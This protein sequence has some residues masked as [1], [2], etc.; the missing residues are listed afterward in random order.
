[1]NSQ[2]LVVSA[3]PVGIF[4]GLLLLRKGILVRLSDKTDGPPF[5]SDAG[6]RH[7]DPLFAQPLAG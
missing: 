2:T 7:G 1:M 5:L 4:L 3:R 6:W